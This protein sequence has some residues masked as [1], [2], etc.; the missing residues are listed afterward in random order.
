MSFF[1]EQRHR[2]E[3]AIYWPIPGQCLLVD[4][5]QAEG[6][7]VGLVLDVVPGQEHES[8]IGAASGRKPGM[9]AGPARTAVI[10]QG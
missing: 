2:Q 9:A 10:S 3:F 4:A 7:Q 5:V 8:V 6:G 1:F